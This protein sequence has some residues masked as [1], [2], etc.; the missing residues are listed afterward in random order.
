MSKVPRIVICEK[1]GTDNKDGSK[2]CI[3]CGNELFRDYYKGIQF[4]NTITTLGLFLLP[5]IIFSYIITFEI[6]RH[7]E[8]QVKQNLNYSVDVNVGVIKSFLEERKRDLLSIANVDMSNLDAIGLRAS[9]YKRFIREKPSFAFIAIAD[10]NGQ[11]IYATNGFNENIAQRMYFQKSSQGEFYNSG[12]F[13]SDLLD[14]T[15]MIISSPLKNQ[16]SE[17]IGIILASISLKTFYDLILDLRIGETSE[18]FLVDEKGVFLSSSKLGGKILVE[19]GHYESDPNPH[20]GERGITVHRDYRGEKVICAFGRF[21][22]FH[23]Y[24]VSEMDVREA[25]APVARLRSVMLYI[26][27]IFGGFLL[28]S[29]IF[30]SRQIT[31]SLKNLTSALKLALDDAH[32]KKNTIDTINIELRKRLSDCQSLSKQLSTSEEY[33]KNIINSI[34]SGVIAID[35]NLQVTYYNNVV[36][37]LFN[38]PGTEKETYSHDSLPILYDETIKREIN[39]VLTN[40]KPFVIKRLLLPQNK[41]ELVLRVSGFPMISNGNVTG[42]T[43]L[44]SDITS[45]EKLR[46]QMADYEKLSAL[47]QLALGAA[48][49]INNPLLGITSYI[50]LLLEDETDVERK[51]QARQVLDNAYRISETVR[52]LLNFARPS[53]PT[54]TKISINRLITETLSFLKH[55]PLFKKINIEKVLA[56]SVPQITAD[57][58][59]IRQVLINI[60]LN[61]AQA[62]PK[63]GTITVSTHKVKFENSVEMKITDTGSGISKEDLK[64]AF[65]PFFTTKKGEGTGLG[66]SISYSY[67]K[68]H[69]GKIYISSNIGVGTEVTIQ[70][71]IRQPSKLKSEVIE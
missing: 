49:E 31:N 35:T 50:E 27:L 14:T 43:L 57:A 8:N 3:K 60:F 46:N 29:S 12:I 68:S 2:N 7:L 13:H 25:L 30:F 36:K 39:N 62:T 33:I 58:N 48:H 51:S 41:R 70:L 45:E 17:I 23:G 64:R 15:A 59:Q 47:S 67:V 54:F 44:V 52:G 10:L 18:I 61:A 53:P 20:T 55:Q 4:R 21:S 16:A 63:G 24:L 1:C 5:F 34:S 40:R 37:D 26:F 19:Y 11:V 9:F 22:D 42:V 65:D 32:T 69:N 66:L 56:E 38:A 71:P 6:S 28:V